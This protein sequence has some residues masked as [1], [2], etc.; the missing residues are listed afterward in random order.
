MDWD[1]IIDELKE[2]QEEDM[3][4]KIESQQDQE[5]IMS[6][7]VK[8]KGIRY[9]IPKE[10]YEELDDKYDFDLMYNNG[11]AK[12]LGLSDDFKFDSGYDY[13]ND[14]SNYY[15]DKVLFYKY[16]ANGDYWKSRKLTDEEAKLHIDDFKKVF[17]NITSDELRYVDY[18]YYNGCDAPDV[19]EE[20]EWD[21]DE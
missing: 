12:E 5:G 6:D 14:K 3:E 4:Y 10:I 20:G 19:F 15:L 11:I 1:E 7:Y 13:D 18:C 21:A 2:E 16:G 17:P 9:R 8:K